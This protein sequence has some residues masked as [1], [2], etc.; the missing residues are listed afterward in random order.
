VVTAGR[1]DAVA[2]GV[3]ASLAATIVVAYA[4]G[5][6]GVALM[7][8]QLVAVGLAAGVTLGRRLGVR[9]D[10][11]AGH[12]P[13]WLWA[14]VVVGT[15]AGLIALVGP[16]LLPPGGGSDLAHHLALVD[17]LERTRHLVDA[18][19]SGPALG[20][21]A[22]YTPGLHLLI[23]IA[24]S[25][26][27]V[28]AFYVAYP[29][30]LATIALKAGFICLIAQ[31]FMAGLRGSHPLGAVLLVLL[32]PRAYSV[33]GFLQA[34]FLSQVGAELFVVAGWWALTLWWAA[35]SIARTVLVGLCGAAVFLVW[36]IWIGPL[37]IAA[38]LAVLL[39]PGLDLRARVGYGALA[40]A[41][42]AL[43]AVL[44]LSRHAA[45][46]RMAG[47]SGA[48]PAFVPGVSG[49]VLI[50]LALAGLAVALRMASARVTTWFLAG[51]VVQAAALYA[52]AQARG[53]AVPYMAMKMI[54]LGVYPV[55]VLAALAIARAVNALPARRVTAGGWAAIALVVAVVTPVARA[56]SVPPPI[57]SPDLYDA[58][59][60]ARA[61]LDPAC[62]DYVVADAE[63]AYW[64]HLAV[65]GQSR[66]SPRTAD[67]D[68]YTANRAAGRWIEGTSL[69][70]AVATYDLL[71]GEVLADAEV[72]HRSGSAVVIGR[73][74]AD[75]D[76]R[77]R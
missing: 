11:P 17:L 19:V 9:V 73:P 10:D 35:P 65:M 70:Y 52:V 71:P 20:E 49:W 69:P 50:A 51:V 38:A 15:G 74:D 28:E 59:R 55:A 2:G 62:V 7:P 13:L 26:I 25:L 68:G 39:A 14:F 40:A 63:Q 30:L 12:A 8:T 33:D 75:V 5:W 42:V 37:M 72:L 56:I 4:L 1:T 36:P 44:H 58:G 48:V 45:W 3:V 34:G 47:A 57:V 54:Y 66:S 60:W 77:R 61:T 18:E 64:L 6:A 76:C 41:P 21:M 16:G 22:H 29:L 24:A 67:I 43:V 53:A 23:V 32:A 46:L 27:G 31:R